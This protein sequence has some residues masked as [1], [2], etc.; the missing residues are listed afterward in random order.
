MVFWQERANGWAYPR[1]TK[2]WERPGSTQ[3]GGRGSN[4]GWLPG[5]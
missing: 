1:L 4:G 2:G 3:L 5:K